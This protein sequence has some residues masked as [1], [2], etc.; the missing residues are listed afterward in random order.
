VSTRI[1]TGM[2]QRSVL[3]DLNRVSE[4]LT[5][6]QEKIAS[7]REITRPSDDPFNTS[8]ALALRESLEGTQQYQRNVLDAQGWQEASEQA[9]SQIT[10]SVEKAR[11]L[12]VQGSSDSADDAAREAIAKEVDQLIAGIKQSANATYK[13]RYVFSGTRTDQA[14]YPMPEPAAPA[15]DTFHGV[16]VQ[17][18]RQIGP[19]VT[20]EVSVNAGDVL[21]GG[22]VAGDTGLLSVLRTVA[23]HLRAGDGAALRDT[24]LSAVD[25]G[26]DDLLGVRALNGSRQNRLDS[27]LS[28]LSQV[29]ESTLSQLSETEDA[30][31][32]KVLVEF[33]SQQAAYQ[34]ALKAGANIVQVSLM[35]FLR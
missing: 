5:R 16:S 8:R 22:Q 25:K 3:A 24:D 12:L 19:G 34:A 27:A 32:A 17:I 2:V 6:T 14:P 15:R 29:E 35:D 20:M 23:D 4:R 28:R 33:N 13:G 18:E 9:L 26:L 1:T 31:I 21:G 30:D 10:E 7:N 11:E